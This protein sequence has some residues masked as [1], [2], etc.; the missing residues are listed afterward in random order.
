[1]AHAAAILS[2]KL[3]E[4]TRFAIQI[5]GISLG[6]WCAGDMA[7]AIDPEH[8][9]FLLS[10][11]PKSACD[12][13]LDVSWAETLEM[14]EAAASFA[15]GGLW[16]AY[17]SS[18]G[19]QFYFSSPAVGPRPYK[20]AWFDPSFTRGH[21][22]LSRPA[23]A[24]GCQIFPLEYPLDELAMMHRLALGEGV[25]VHALGLADGDGSGY[26]FLG[27]SGA[28][29]STTARLWKEQPGVR[30]LSDD[31]II[32][33]KQDN[34]FWMYGTPWHGDAG[35]ASPGRAPLSAIFFLEQSPINE[36]IPI[37]QPKAAAELFARAFVPHYLQGGIHFS[38]DFVEQ[39]TR[40]VPC[41]IFRF[42]PTPD[43]VEVIRHV[44]V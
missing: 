5:G 34:K 35:V 1:M 10:S 37:A 15:S 31:R 18:T 22:V 13:E 4:A 17:N 16:S 36:L 40:S 33:R 25:E 38:L 42:A 29:K 7:L 3:N 6:L 41:S 39:V 28:G 20:A 43:A 9:P 14:P 44:R 11:A 23:F 19:T 30:L 21:V 24:A 12:M 26:L 32:L 2:T 8:G 27:H